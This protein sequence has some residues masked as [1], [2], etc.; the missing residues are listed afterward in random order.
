[1]GVERS[2]RLVMKVDALTFKKAV[3]AIIKAG[4]KDALRAALM[5]IYRMKLDAWEAEDFSSLPNEN[6]AA[7]MWP[8]IEPL[9][10]EN[11]EV[12][13]NVD[14]IIDGPETIEAEWTEVQPLQIGPQT[15]VTD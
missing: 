9:L 8:R 11:W 13:A 2:G 1:M 14:D 10:P 15:P 3:I 7:V 12:D 4:H 5:P 6:A